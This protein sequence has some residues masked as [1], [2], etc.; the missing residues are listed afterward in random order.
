LEVSAVLNEDNNYI[1]FG[2]EI[3]SQ[4]SLPLRAIEEE[5]WRESGTSYECDED[6]CGY[7][8]WSESD[9]SGGFLFRSDQAGTYILRLQL[10]SPKAVSGAVAF[11][12]RQTVRTAFFY[13]L[14]IILWPLGWILG[15]Y[16]RSRKRH[17]K[18][19]WVASGSQ[20]ADGL[21][22]AFTLPKPAKP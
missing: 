14:G 3:V 10:A 6:G 18:R 13:T 11:E 12:L 7:Y 19:L 15:L 17:L 22:D 4:D 9:L 8:D 21:F 2:A 16:Y 20:V 1:T 5:F